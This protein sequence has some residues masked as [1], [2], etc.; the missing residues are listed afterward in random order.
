V[1]AAPPRW[2]RES[3]RPLLPLIVLV[4]AAL[5][6][7]VTANA[8]GG[9]KLKCFADSPATCTLNSAT[10]ATIDSTQG[11]DAGVYLTNGKSTNGTPIANA[12]F[13][14]TFFCANTTDLS[15][16]SGGGAMRWS[17]P[18]NT[19]GNSKTTEG[20][21]FLDGANCLAGGTQPSGGALT[22]STTVAT[23]PVFFGAGSYTNWDAFAAANPTYTISGALPF[24]ISDVVTAQAAIVSNVNSTKA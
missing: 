2:V 13:S 18:I 1:Q 9:G 23:C 22:V 8:A 11:G 5:T 6:V 17:I 19:D 7:A 20:Y 21:A 14:F 10:S 12:D 24:V 16:S 4:A 3:S 15:S